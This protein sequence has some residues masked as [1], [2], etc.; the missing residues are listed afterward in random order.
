MGLLALLLSL[1]DPN[2]KGGKFGFPV[3]NTIGAT[4]QPNGW[5]DNWVDFYRDRRLGHQLQLLDDRQLNQLGDKL[6]PNLEVFF[7][8]IQGKIK[9][10][11]LHGDLWSGNIAGVE[12]KPC[13]FDPATYYGHHEAEFGM[14]WCAGF[15]GD[16]WRAYHEVI[17]KAPGFDRRKDLYLLYH[18]LNHT[19]LFGGGYYNTSLRIM[20][21]LVEQI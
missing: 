12:G 19:N 3:D 17:P 16:F 15:T 5:M 7:D 6:L 18:Y 4:P 20:Q 9:P 13:I 11:V 10:S 21:R 8:D 2:A 1:Q 14:S